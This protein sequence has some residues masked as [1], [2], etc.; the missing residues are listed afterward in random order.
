MPIPFIIFSFLLSLA[1][2]AQADPYTDGKQAYD[3]MNLQEALH[4]FETAKEKSTDNPG[5]VAEILLYESATYFFLGDKTAATQKITQALAQDPTCQPFKV[6]FPAAL[7]KI[8]DNAR[9]KQMKAHEEHAFREIIDTPKDIALQN[10]QVVFEEN[11]RQ[12]NVRLGKGLFFSS[13]IPLG[14][15]LG[16]GISSFSSGWTQESALATWG[17]GIGTVFATA[18]LTL[19]LRSYP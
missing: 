9:T 14:I 2:H 8:F 13:L 10:I 16:Y 12:K 17:L 5:L 19:W 4:Y 11:Q 1:G 18:G 6:G 3:E 7:K 15:G